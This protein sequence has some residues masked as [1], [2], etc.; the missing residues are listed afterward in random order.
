ME[1][2]LA[3]ITFFFHLDFQLQWEEILKQVLNKDL[4]LNS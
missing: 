1:A 4:N 3:E 2:S